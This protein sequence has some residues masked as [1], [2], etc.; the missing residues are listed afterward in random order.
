MKLLALRQDALSAM[1]Q[2]NYLREHNYRYTNRQWDYNFKVEGIEPLKPEDAKTIC[3]L[4][5]I[6]DSKLLMG[7][8]LSDYVRAASS[9]SFDWP[10]LAGIQKDW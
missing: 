1:A 9:S 4:F 2:G 10:Q 6:N 5:D 8:Y 7:I 3:Q